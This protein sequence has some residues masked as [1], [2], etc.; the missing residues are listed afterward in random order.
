MILKYRYIHNMTWPKIGDM[1]CADERT[2]Q[3]WHNKAIARINLPENAINLKVV[4][5][6]R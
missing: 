5:V 3:R 2:V 4:V 1:L 6:C